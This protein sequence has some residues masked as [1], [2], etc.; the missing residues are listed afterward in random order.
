VRTSSGA[1]A[2][3]STDGLSNACCRRAASTY[4]PIAWKVWPI[5]VSTGSVTWKMKFG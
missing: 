1:S 4:G 3:K 2:W 5:E